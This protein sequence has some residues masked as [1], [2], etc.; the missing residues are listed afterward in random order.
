MISILLFFTVIGQTIYISKIY[1]NAQNISQKENNIIQ[2]AEPNNKLSK[3]KSIFDD[4]DNEFMS[5]HFKEFRKIKEQM[6]KAFD[7]AF[8]E[9]NMHPGFNDDFTSI[10]GSSKIT[11]NLNLN[12]QNEPDRF[13]I[14]LKLPNSQKNNINVKLDGQKLT[15]YGDVKEQN[16]ES[17]DFGKQY[18]EYSSKFS[19][20]MILPEK[21]KKI[22]LQLNLKKKS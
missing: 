6:D 14:T 3:Q 11:N 9:F 16:E 15:V 18:R 20:S 10:F 2:L 8:A 13:K 12:L 1:S 22:L 17:N 5:N 21:V 19:R 7:E 4:F